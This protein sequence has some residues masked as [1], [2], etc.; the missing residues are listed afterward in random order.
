VSTRPHS[1]DSRPDPASSNPAISVI[2]STRNRAHYL[3][4][5]LQSLA[6]QECAIQYEVIVIDNGSTDATPALLDE[7]CRRD[8]RFRTAREPRPG[9]SR[10]KNAGIRMARASLLLYTDDDMRVH[11]RWVES[12]R[13]LFVRHEGEVMV[14]GGPVVPMPHD[15]GTWPDWLAQ[16]ALVDAGLLDHHEERALKKF[17]YAW[18]GNMAVPKLLFEQLGCWNESAGLQADQRVTRMESEFFEDTELQDRVRR[19]GGSSWFCPGAVV[20]H[21]VD[22]QSVTPRRIAATAFARGRNDFCQHALRVWHQMDMVP[23]RNAL[24]AALALAESLGQW[25]LWLILFRFSRRKGF[26]ERARRAAYASGHSLESL[27]AGRS[28][29]R[30]FRGAARVTF[31]A[32]SLLLRLTPDVA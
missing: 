16:A 25:G 23:K 17:E 31:P 11:P 22:R 2:V 30:I 26:F 28:R 1:E 3:P 10:G 32:R 21:R 24:Q 14:A 13:A 7:W 12:Y 18:G 29:M 6:A 19:T 9:L 5:V 20:Y 27:R 8:S 15:L 4:E